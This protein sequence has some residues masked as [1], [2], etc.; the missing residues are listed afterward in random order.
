MSDPKENI[1]D[2]RIKII[3]QIA[4]LSRLL[5]M[6]PSEGTID[7]REPMTENTMVLSDWLDATR[8]SF[9]SLSLLISKALDIELQ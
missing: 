6:V 4:E 3:A 9:L 5:G 1:E 8:D 7:V 2:Q